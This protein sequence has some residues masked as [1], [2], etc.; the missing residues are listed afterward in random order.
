MTSGLDCRLR[1][2]I[3]EPESYAHRRRAL[4]VKK[5]LSLI[6]L[7]VAAASCTKARQP[8]AKASQTVSGPASRLVGS[9]IAR[10]IETTDSAGRTI[11]SSRP[12]GMIIYT[13]EGRMAVQIMVLP[14]PL[15][16]PVPEG[17]DEVNAWS[18]EQTRRVV[19][20]Y[21]A[22]FGTYEVDTVRHIVTHHVEGEL[23]P[24]YVGA[25]YARRYEVDGDRLLLSATKP[26]EHWRVVWDRVK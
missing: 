14:R 1:L 7:A 22:Y 16:P 12:V 10:A 11:E 13:A 9:W 24:N 18:S 19:E 25:A 3:V 20:T 26:D 6:A 17:P 8:E 15:V 21:D 23:R 2:K 5:R 4:I